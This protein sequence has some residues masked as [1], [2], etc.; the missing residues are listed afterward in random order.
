[1]VGG[2]VVL[3]VTEP[4]LLAF[5]AGRAYEATTTN[6]GWM[7]LFVTTAFIAFCFFLALTRYGRLRLGAPGE[8]P[9]FGFGT[10]LGMIFSCGMG[11]GLVFW[12]VAEPLTHFDQPPMGMAEP[13]SADAARVALRYAVFHWGFHQWANFAVVGLAIAYVRFR[14]GSKGLISECFRPLLGARVDGPW[15]KAIDVLAVLATTVGVA[16]TLGLGA[17]QINSGLAIE[18]GLSYGPGTQ[19]RIMAGV[20]VLFTLS[21]VTPLEKGLRFMSDLNMLLAAALLAFVFFAGPTPFITAAMTNTVGEYLSNVVGMSLAM[22][23]FTGEDWIERWT[24]FYWAWGLSWAPFV[25][26]FIARISR[27]RT[28]REFSIGVVMVPAALSILWF[29]TFGGTALYF[30]LFEGAGL[31]DAARAELPSALFATLDR[32]PFPDLLSLAALVLVALFVV[33]SANSATFVLGMF[34]SHGRLDPSR[35]V[36]LVWGGLQL[37]VASVLLLGGG[38]EAIQT[39]SIVAGFPFVVLMIFMAVGL[40]RGLAREVEELELHDLL[41]K[42]RLEQLLAE[43]EAARAPGGAEGGARP[44]A[45]SEPGASRPDPEA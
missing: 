10:W 42:R 45:A 4:E 1:L 29:A 14:L 38:L 7:Y 28:I 18:Y 31:A 40:Y 22:T 25:G 39:L 44:E 2:F 9:E 3:G 37:G 6:F 15:G 5:Q 30:D 16:T 20:G 19:L 27:G 21:A 35:L 43:T 8:A 41:F 11:V 33:T 13:R 24:I 12:G 34:T 32:L 26:S 23:P 36:R 17:L